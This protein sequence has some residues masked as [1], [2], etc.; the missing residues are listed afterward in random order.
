MNFYC[1]VASIHESPSQFLIAN[2]L[3]P[4]LLAFRSRLPLHSPPAS[5]NEKVPLDIN[6]QRRFETL[7][8]K[9]NS[10]KKTGAHDQIPHDPAIFRHEFRSGVCRR[11]LSQIAIVQQ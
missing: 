10:Q 11:N 7:P 4:P 9:P 6:S 2:Q 3:E 5:G 1:V 8:L